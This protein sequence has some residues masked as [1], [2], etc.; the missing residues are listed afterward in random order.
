MVDTT[1]AAADARRELSAWRRD[2]AGVRFESV[3]GFDAVQERRALSDDPLVMAALRGDAADLIGAAT[4]PGSP[5]SARGGSTDRPGRT[6]AE[7][8]QHGEPIHDVTHELGSRT[9]R[10]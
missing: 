6:A 1:D 4:C 5:A 9:R 10:T 3:D 7:M 2:V 8:L